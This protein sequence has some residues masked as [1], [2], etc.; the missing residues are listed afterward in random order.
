MG[1]EMCIRDRRDSEARTTAHEWA[2]CSASG[3]NC[4]LS[5]GESSEAMGYFDQGSIRPPYDA[6]SKFN[7][8][9]AHHALPCSTSSRA[10]AS[11]GAAV[12]AP[13]GGLDSCELW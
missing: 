7:P 6:I 12:R 8:D 2:A 13:S 3:R 4:G 10:S 9:A 1:S 5:L 11:E